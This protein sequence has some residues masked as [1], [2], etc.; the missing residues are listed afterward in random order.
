M[1]FEEPC[2]TNNGE[3]KT[4]NNHRLLGNAQNINY[5]VNYE[6]LCNPSSVILQ[7]QK[8]R[9]KNGSQFFTMKVGDA[10]Y[11]SFTKPNYVNANIDD[12]LPMENP[13]DKSSIFS[14]QNSY[15]FKPVC[16]NHGDVKSER[17]L[18]H[19]KGLITI[20]NL[21]RLSSAKETKKKTQNYSD[22]AGNNLEPILKKSKN[23]YT[24]DFDKQ[25]NMDSV[26]HLSAKR[27]TRD[28]ICDEKHYWCWYINKQI[29]MELAA[30]LFLKPPK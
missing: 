20:E 3:D 25:S 27:Y 26:F 15:I 13:T 24:G 21:S 16:G 30:P 29:Q 18:K 14:F 12:A 19:K 10:K 8:A 9:K 4:E 11:I 1:F 2:R 28:S 5:Q 23:V 7:D 22:V 6:K 17:D